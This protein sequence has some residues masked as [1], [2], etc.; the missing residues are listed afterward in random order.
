MIKDSIYL[1]GDTILKCTKSGTFGSDRFKFVQ[2]L[3]CSDYVICGGSILDASDNV[4]KP[5]VCGMNIY[6][7][8]EQLAEYSV[9]T[10][11]RFGDNI[12][13]YTD[14][15]ISKYSY[16]DSET[17]K[18]LGEYLRC[19]KSVYSLDLMPLYN[20][21]SNL[22]VENVDLSTGYLSESY[23]PRYKTTL[24]P[25]K[26]N[27]KY[28]IHINCNTPV[29][30]K[31]I[32]YGGSVLRDAENNWILPDNSAEST[33]ISSVSFNTPFSYSL[34]CRDTNMQRLEKFLYLAIQIPMLNNSPISVIEGDYSYDMDMAMNGTITSNNINSI[35]VS[36]PS[37]SVHKLLN[38]HYAESKPF[39]NKLLGYLVRNT[40]DIR[41][42][43]PYNVDRLYKSMGIENWTGL[44]SDELRKKLF[45][46]YME[47]KDTHPDLNYFDILGY[48]DKDIETAITN[49]FIYPDYNNIEV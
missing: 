8:S 26:Y 44:W 12:I 38:S 36:K 32:L 28:N 7:N 49:G 23:N 15:F 29:Y 42:E 2:S 39:S 4:T 11:Y 37:L 27:R 45:T 22:F 21:F 9:L 31:P 17:H 13:G 18:R 6:S 41:E 25:I 1:S 33:V 14:N 46:S 16:Y 35:L 40:V 30:V 34:V 10:K 19:L 43:I 3:V 20:C 47:L 5:L 24:I 48:L